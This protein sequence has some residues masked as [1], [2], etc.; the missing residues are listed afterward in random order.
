M[1]N[2]MN[3]IDYREISSRIEKV[4]ST[5]KALWGKMNAA[6]MICHATDILREATGT[7]LTKDM[8]NFFSRTFI[9][10]LSLYILPWPKGKLPTSPYYDAEK[11]GTSPSD[12]KNDKD[13]LLKMLSNM[14]SMPSLSPHPFFGKLSNKEWGRATY[15][16]LD[17]HL[18]QFGC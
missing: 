4:D 16:H 8:S 15:L 9:K 17:H 3:D 2:I 18:K 12:L 10:W 6:Q 5:S 1:K 7:R 14:R 13:V 11:K